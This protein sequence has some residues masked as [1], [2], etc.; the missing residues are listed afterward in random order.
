MVLW[1]SAPSLH[2]ERFVGPPHRKNSAQAVQ[3]SAVF[4]T[5]RG[6]SNCCRY[7]VYTTPYTG[8]AAMDGGFSNL[9]TV[10]TVKIESLSRLHPFSLLCV[11]P[12]PGA[13]NAVPIPVF[14][15][16]QRI[17]TAAPTA[18]NHA[19]GGSAGPVMAAVR[20]SPIQ[21]II[22]NSNSKKDAHANRQFGDCFAPR[23]TW[24]RNGGNNNR[25][26]RRNVAPARSPLSI[27]GDGAFHSFTVCGAPGCEVCTHDDTGVD[28][29]GGRGGLGVSGHHSPLF[30]P[31]AGA[32]GHSRVPSP[33]FENTP[34]DKPGR[35]L[36]QHAC[37]HCRM[38]FIPK[39]DPQ[40][41]TWSARTQVGGVSRGWGAAGVAAAGTGGVDA[42]KASCDG[43]PAEA[44]ECVP[45]APSTPSPT[46]PPN[47]DSA[48]AG[49]D[50]GV[51]DYSRRWHGSYSS[52]SDRSTTT[53]SA[54]GGG[55]DGNGPSFSHSNPRAETGN[56]YDD[57]EEHAPG[58]CS[59]D[60]KMSY[61]LTNPAALR[62]Q[63][64]AAA[65]KAAARAAHAESVKIQRAR[66][67]G[68]RC[69]EQRV[70]DEG[71]KA[72]RARD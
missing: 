28:G 40:A 65:A 44:A 66:Q 61:M 2:C 46:P 19:H 3:P 32:A 64:A 68:Q 27:Y 51:V 34:L 39:V 43:K 24:P 38:P 48:S 9:L 50:G 11:H 31:G 57:D 22:R 52:S 23:N 62:R 37:E 69:S 8:I 56:G 4:V 5:S 59:G 47:A 1:P 63:R 33:A 53:S 45:T 55:S 21:I 72:S 17:S 41:T 35:R 20:G 25:N 54:S 15:R 6:P 14:V 7:G 12:S 26:A 36:I 10:A 58:F 71:T 60:C 30:I 70:R 42:D 18:S 49:A 13:C 29:V 16:S 67:E